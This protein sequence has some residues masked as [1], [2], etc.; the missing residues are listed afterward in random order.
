[1][2]RHEELE[3]AVAELEQ[4][5]IKYATRTTEGGHIEIV[6]QVSPDK[7][8]RRVFTS[9]TPSDH[10]TRL[11]ARAFIRRALRQDGID[12]DKKQT[13]ATKKSPAVLERALQAPRQGPTIPEQLE[14][15]RS[16][17]ADIVDLLLDVSNAIAELKSMQSAQ[18]P[19]ILASP[20]SAPTYS[21]P[22][23]S[24]RSK[25]AIEYV[26]A[27]WNSLDALARDMDLPVNI[28]YRKLYYLKNLGLVELEGGKCR[29]TPTDTEDAPQISEASLSSEPAPLLDDVET[30][31]EVAE[32]VVDEVTETSLQR[33]GDFDLRKEDALAAKRPPTKKAPSIR[34]TASR[35]KPLV[36]KTKPTAKATAAKKKAS[37][38]ADHAGHTSI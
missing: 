35:K 22:K 36:A 12:I 15:L 31:A 9:K 10:R 5:N 27:G 34:K 6:W 19:T 7:E 20:E 26:S 33:T 28:T 1:M 4:H 38:K 32:V 8:I 21:A 30:P 16:D 11:N 23:P 2:K 29:L 37:Q 17:V 3:F 13:T 24:V 14:A 18:Q 25:K